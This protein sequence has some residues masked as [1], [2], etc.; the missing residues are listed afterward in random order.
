[1]PGGLRFTVFLPTTT[2]PDQVAYL[3]AVDLL[4]SDPR[5]IP[6]YTHTVDDPPILV[7]WYWSQNDGIWI[8][9]TIALAFT[10]LPDNPNPRDQLRQVKEDIKRLYV[11]AGSPQQELW[12]TL[13]PLEVL[14]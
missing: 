12:C 1:M 8:R 7:G 10:D 13:Q 5:R 4:R 14:Q 2:V 3:Q 9:D 6:G 11:D